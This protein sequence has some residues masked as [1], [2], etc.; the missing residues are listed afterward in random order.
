METCN[1]KTFLLSAWTLAKEN[2]LFFLS[3]SLGNLL[4]DLPAEVGIKHAVMV[5]SC[6]L[7]ACVVLWIQAHARQYVSVVWMDWTL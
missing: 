2:S 3:G 4:V 1:F 5:R 7:L 6:A